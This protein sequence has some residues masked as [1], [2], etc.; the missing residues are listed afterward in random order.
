MNTEERTVW[1][2]QNIKAKRLTR[3]KEKKKKHNNNRNGLGDE[4]LDDDHFEF[5]N[6]QMLWL[7]Q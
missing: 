7:K 6:E 3:E 1:H 4:N 5:I 2:S